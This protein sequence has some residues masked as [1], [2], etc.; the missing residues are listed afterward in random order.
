[1]LLLVMQPS[2]D[3]TGGTITAPTIVSNPISQSVVVGGSVQFL[4]VA[5]GG[6][7]SYQWYKNGSVIIGATLTTYTTPPAVYSTDNNASFTVIVSNSAGVA[8]STPAILTV[9]QAVT[10]YLYELRNLLHD[11]NGQMWPDNELLSYIN[12]ARRRVCQDTKCLRTIIPSIT[13][14]QGQ[15]LYAINTILPTVA[16][17]V[18][19]IMNIYLYW[20]NSRYPLQYMAFSDFSAQLRQWQLLQQV[21]VAYT[22]MGATQIYFGPNPDQNYV[23][24]WDVAL[25]PPDLISDQST[26]VI[27][28]PF[29][30][31][32]KFWAAYLAKFKEQALGETQI[33]KRE[34]VMQMLMASRAFQ[35]R[36]LPNVYAR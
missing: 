32:V 2:L 6:G 33:F 14:T 12:Q 29:T 27:P 4:V 8:T 3:V 24:D 19:D 18:I 16:G 34:Y 21:P 13:I 31:P 22:R 1:M 9:L 20:G 7:L 10:T 15:E 11:P 5:L 28:P 25:N 17:Y 23:T 30:E 36:I 26:E 35:T